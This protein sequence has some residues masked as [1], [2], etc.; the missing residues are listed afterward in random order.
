[1]SAPAERESEWVSIAVTA[2]IL[3]VTDR[4]VRSY[5]SRG[6]LP[7]SRIGTT[8]TARIRRSD[9][10]ALMRPIPVVEAS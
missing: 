1:M 4:T 3:S 2:S 9:I 10:D 5:I 8:R 7:A 6:I